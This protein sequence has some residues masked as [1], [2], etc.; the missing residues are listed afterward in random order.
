MREV[1]SKRLYVRGGLEVL[2]KLGHPTWI[3]EP[4]F[5]TLGRP[6]LL[7]ASADGLGAATGTFG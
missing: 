2:N 1:T 4:H 6:S 7:P 3:A 5:P